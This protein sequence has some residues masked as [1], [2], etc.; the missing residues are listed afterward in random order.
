MIIIAGFQWMTS[1]GN[2]SQ[3]TK[4]K[5]R[6]EA[7]VVGL[8]LLLSAYVIARVIDPRLVKMNPLRVPQLKSIELL[9]GATSCEK[10]EEYGYRV[11]EIQGG[12]ECGKTGQV[13]DTKDVAADVQSNIEVGASCRFTGCKDQSDVCIAASG[14]SARCTSCE[15]A[16]ADMGYTE[17]AL[18]MGGKIAPLCSAIEAQLKARETDPLRQYACVYETNQYFNGCVQV[19]STNN[20]IDCA[21]LQVQAAGMGAQACGLYSQLV[22]ISEREAADK[23]SQVLNNLCDQDVCRLSQ[24]AGIVGCQSSIVNLPGGSYA[25]CN[26]K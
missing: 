18:D 25:V 5:E 20:Y 11:E 8:V 14:G 19:A 21:A 7:V 2:Q 3:V 15:S 10:L 22:D 6:I 17:T 12:R 23:V 16:T 4:A 1:R 13:T 24:A 26:A 9:S